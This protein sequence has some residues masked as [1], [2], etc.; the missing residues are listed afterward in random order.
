MTCKFSKYTT[1][2]NMYHKSEAAVNESK[3]KNGDEI[4]KTNF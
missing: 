1:I 2:K 4:T 3:P